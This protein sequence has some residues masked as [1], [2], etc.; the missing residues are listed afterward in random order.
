MCHPAVGAIAT[1]AGTAAQMKAAKDQGKAVQEAA[2]LNAK[3]ALIER[4]QSRLEVNQ[5]V[6]DRLEDLDNATDT[7]NA[8][9]G[10]LNRDMDGSINAF[11]KGQIDI[12]NRDIVRAKVSGVLREGQS[13]MS[14]G[15]EIQRGKNAL[16]A[17]K[18]NSIS[19][20]ASGLYTLSKIGIT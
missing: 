18:I 17:G 6:N 5:F 13:V 12:A 8:M 15:R 19:M 20:M 2:T 9:F 11:R 4:E 10:F 14:A 3:Q 16:A 7:N 1:I